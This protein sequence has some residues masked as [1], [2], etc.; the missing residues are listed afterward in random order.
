M[1]NT[2]NNPVNSTN[3]FNPALKVSGV[4]KHY[5]LGS[6]KTVLNGIELKCPSQNM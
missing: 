3:N 1:S 2:E 5:G 6:Y 4:Y